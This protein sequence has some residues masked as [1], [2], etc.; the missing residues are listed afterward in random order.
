MGYLTDMNDERIADIQTFYS[1]LALLE[2][3][4]GG[5]RM[6]V[7]T[8]GRLRWPRRGVYFFMEN[9]ERRSSSGS[10]R[11]IVRVGTHALKAGSK[12]NLWTRLSQHRGQKNTGGGNH[13]GS[14]FRLIVG[15]ALIAR[16]GYQSAT[17]GDGNSAAADIR[18]AELDL[19][20]EVSII[21]GGMPF[22]WLEVGDEP[23]A[24][25]LRGD[26]E[27][28]AIALLSN[29]G[30]QPIDPPSAEWL[31]L[32]CGRERVRASGLWNSNHVNERYDPAFLE[33]MKHLK[34]PLIF[35]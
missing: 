25:S 11:R 5:A 6:L 28:N 13:R 8:S 33:R 32:W 30:K 14:I 21:I 9:S 20:R 19:E 17:W 23:G 34:P 18:G 15:T 31:G 26:I 27:R 1:L 7:E 24:E 22:L 12:T 3:K 10:G 29:F 2:R 35:R 16:N 4:T